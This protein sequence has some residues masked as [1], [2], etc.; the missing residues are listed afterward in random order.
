MTAGASVWDDA[1]LT[2]DAFLDGRVR[3]RQPR[4]GYRAATDPVLLAAA[5]A[6]RPGDRVLD[7]GCGVGAASMCLCARHTVEAHGLET[8]AP[9]AALA[10]INAPDLTVWDGDLFAPPA[11]LSRIGFD[12]VMSNPPYYEPSGAA[13]PDA[14]RDLARREATGADAWVA[15]CLRRV[16]SGGR[17]AVIHLADRLPDILTGLTGAGDI[18]VL[19]LQARAGRPA[20]RVIVTARK[21]ARGPF[22]LAPPLIIHDGPSH[23]ADR[24]DFTG[25][26]QSVLRDGE[27]LVF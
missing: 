9:Y 15:A 1:D 19:P 27:P 6:A 5:V 3:L 17:I 7:V 21:G 12:W 11:A 16:R 24:N 20:K 14:G 25:A 18:A 23:M 26:A 10:R 4:K 2:E 22:R 13:S 8:Q